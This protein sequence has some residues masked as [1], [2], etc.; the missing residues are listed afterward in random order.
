[1]SGARPRNCVV[2]TW[3]S[4]GTDHRVG[5]EDRTPWLIVFGILEVLL[6]L[7]F[8]LI[9]PFLFI[10]TIAVASLEESSAASPT[11]AMLV[12][13]LLVYLLLSVWFIWLGIGSILA[14]RWARAL[15]LIT[16]W[17]WLVTGIIVLLFVLIFSKGIND[18]IIGAGEMPP[19]TAVVVNII[20]FGVTGLFYVVIPGI[21]VLFYRSK[22][23]K[24]TCERKDP[25]VRWT[26]RC[27]L[28]VLAISLGSGIAAFCMP[29][30]GFYGWAIP[31]FGTIVTGIA[32]AAVALSGMCL[33]GYIA[34]GAYRLSLQAWWCALAGII[35]WGISAVLTFSSDGLLEYYETMNF[36]EGQMELIRQFTQSHSAWFMVLSLMWIVVPVGFLL[37][38]KRYF[39]RPPELPS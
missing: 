2:K 24:S 36:S 22:H 8:A 17:F 12:P 10:G 1:M 30:T 39:V 4:P 11:V 32:G 21:L 25:R 5:F 33:L 3:D 29:L 27:P 31:F 35:A 15:L 18:Q 13:S 20:I 6:G 34:L 14:R 28:P 19:G 37:Y 38:T 7:L 16:S 23:V 26:D 9:V